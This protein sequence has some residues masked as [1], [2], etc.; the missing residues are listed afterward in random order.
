MTNAEIK[1]V[2]CDEGETPQ[3][4]QLFQG[5]LMSSEYLPFGEGDNKVSLHKVHVD[6]VLDTAQYISLLKMMAEHRDVAVR[7]VE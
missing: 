2:D 7:L 4:T 6:L 3:L 1:I 5:R